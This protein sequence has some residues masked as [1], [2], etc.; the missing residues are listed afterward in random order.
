M[1]YLI[2]YHIN[3]KVYIGK[4]LHSLEK[5]FKE[6]CNDAFRERNEKRPLYNAMRKYGI[7]H[8]NIELIEECGINEVSEREILWIATYNSYYNG[9]NATL[10]GD[11]KV[12]IDREK[13]ITS[14]QQ[15][16]NIRKVAELLNISKDTVAYILKNNNIV[17][18]T[19]QQ[20]SVEERGHKVKCID[21]NNNVLFYNVSFYTIT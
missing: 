12:L 15:F 21:N 10:G 5:R 9:Y 2:Y 13:V 7:E 11:G 1:L 3:T 19:S 17:I 14:Y 4:T 18:K 8:F 6:H 16:Q 20:I